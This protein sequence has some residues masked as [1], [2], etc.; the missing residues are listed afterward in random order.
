MSEATSEG[1]AWVVLHLR[2]PQDGPAGIEAGY[3]EISNNLAGTPGLLRNDLLKHALDPTSFA[4]LSE[5]ASLAAFHEW[6]KG[7]SHRGT[8]SPLRAYQDS[9]KGA[10]FELYEVTASY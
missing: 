10:P 1:R 3:H 7:A 5:W 2:V 4:V 8:T 6:E 9:S